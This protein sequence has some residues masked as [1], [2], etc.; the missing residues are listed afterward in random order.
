MLSLLAFIGF[1]VDGPVQ[2]ETDNTGAYNLCHRY[3]SAQHSRHVERKQFKM[4]ELRGAGV[5]EVKH[6]DGE[7]NSADMFTKI[8]GRQV[9]ERHRATVLNM[10][11]G[12]AV[13]TER[14]ARARA[15]A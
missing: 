11:A 3:T 9:F 10:A 14:A 8:L 12:A 5:V 4:R 7:Q 15:P 1:D 13:E 2:V 6:V